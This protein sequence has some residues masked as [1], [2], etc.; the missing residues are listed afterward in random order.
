MKI[1]G[2]N[3]HRPEINYPCKWTFKVIGDNLDLMIGTIERV[4][5]NIHFDLTP[6]NIS[7]NGNYYSLNLVVEVT[8]E[9]MRNR[10]YNDLQGEASIKYIL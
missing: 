4:L 1:L 3:N 2:E 6:S 9:T 7:K 8:D 5:H 10:I